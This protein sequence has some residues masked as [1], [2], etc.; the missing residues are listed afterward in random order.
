VVIAKG[1]LPESVESLPDDKK[2]DAAV[3]YRAELVKLLEGLL[4]AEQEV[5]D[6]KNED[7]LKTITG[8]R[9]IEKEGH[10]QF[11]PKE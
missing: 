1:I 6:G 7:A 4:K 10:E 2:A 5:L 11:R 3:K 9:E 8:L